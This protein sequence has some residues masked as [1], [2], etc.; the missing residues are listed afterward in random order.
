MALKSD[1][2]VPRWSAG[3]WHYG[4]QICLALW[5]WT[6]M[7]LWHSNLLGTMALNHLGTMALKLL[8]TMALNHL[9]T[10]ALK[11]DLDSATVI[12]RSMALWHSNL[13]WTVPRLSAGLWH[14]GTQIWSEQCHG[15]QQVNGTMALK[16]DLNSATVAS[17]LM[18]LWHWNPLALWHWTTLALWYYGTQ[19]WSHSAKVLK[20]SNP[21]PDSAIEKSQILIITN[22]D[23]FYRS[24]AQSYIEQEVPPTRAALSYHI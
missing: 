23:F 7:A 22:Q 9:G 6:T 4:T 16:S 3:L 15:Y 13:I 11:S 5:H 12:S 20:H 17:R 8:G 18:A 2:I 21:N 14:Y 10:M 1:L 19:G 24:M